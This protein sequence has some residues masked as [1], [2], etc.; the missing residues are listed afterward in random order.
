MRPKPTFLPTVAV[1]E[2]GCGTA[3]HAVDAKLPVGW[4]QRAGTVWCTDCTRQGIPTRT[5]LSGGLSGKHAGGSPRR[6][7]AA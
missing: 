5:L 6:R 4:T 2:C 7:S 3:H 1:F